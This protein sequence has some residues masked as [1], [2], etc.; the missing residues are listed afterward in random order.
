MTGRIFHVPVDRLHECQ[1]TS[2]DDQPNTLIQRPNA[3]ID[4]F[5]C[6]ERSPDRP[7]LHERDAQMYRSTNYIYR[8]ADYIVDRL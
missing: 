4:G 7:C 1:V 6:T 5:S 8:T 3:N 2:T